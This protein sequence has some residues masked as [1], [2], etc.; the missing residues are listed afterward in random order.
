FLKLECLQ[1]LYL[2][3]VPFFEGHLHQ[4]LRSMKTPLDDLAV[5]DCTLSIL[6]WN[7]L[8]EFLCVSQLQQLNLQNVR[9]TDLSSEPLRVL[10]VK[11]GPT[12][13]SLDLEN[14]HIEDCHLY[15]ILPAL[16][17]CAQL[18]KFSFYG[19]QISMCAKRN[20]LR[21]TAGLRKL[22]LELYPVPQGS[23]DYSGTLHMELTREYCEELMDMLKAIREPGRVF[24][25]TDHCHRCDN[26]YIYN[27]TT[28]CCD[29][30]SW[31]SGSA[32]CQFQDGSGPTGAWLDTI[33]HHYGTQVQLKLHWY[34]KDFPTPSFCF[35]HSLKVYLKIMIILEGRGSVLN[36]YE[37]NNST[38][39]HSSTLD[40]E[41]FEEKAFLLLRKE[42][43]KG[44]TMGHKSSSIRMKTRAMAL[45]SSSA[46][47]H[48]GEDSEAC[49]LRKQDQLRSSQGSRDEET[50]Q[51]KEQ[52]FPKPQ[53]W[54]WHAWQDFSLLKQAGL[55]T[56]PILKITFGVLDCPV[57]TIAS[58]WVSNSSTR[59]K[60]EVSAS[61]VVCSVPRQVEISS[62]L[63]LSV[64]EGP[65]EPQSRKE[66]KPLLPL[67][68]QLLLPLLQ[69]IIQVSK[70]LRSCTLKKGGNQLPEQRWKSPV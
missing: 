44:L 9:F 45:S 24:F 43:G 59:T 32:H 68:L 49:I 50:V 69:R 12:L 30:A 46:E 51:S 18:T 2:E 57:L 29:T 35:R 58:V 54:R 1:K 3:T 27:K 65:G 22:R 31:F 37:G 33:C 66:D 28:M 42:S 16:S 39:I 5:T 67:L 56:D 17:S 41:S 52:T 11:A 25:G 53:E 47:I 15:A 4:L 55:P 40:P 26:R 62:G 6:E 14:C 63:L 21:Q 36:V 20:L 64:T 34:G 13:L 10:L 19:N 7:S 70:M 48:L 60:R 23:Y 8:S 38:K 61:E